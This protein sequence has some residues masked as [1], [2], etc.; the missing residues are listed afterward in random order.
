VG[1]I[2]RVSE[3]AIGGCAFVRVDVPTVGERLAFTKLLGQSSIFAITPCSEEAARTVAAN[4]A[5]R[6]ITMYAPSVP[7]RLE[8]DEDL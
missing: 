4:C 1:V 6:P 2:S 8:F 7:S 5:D 3:Q